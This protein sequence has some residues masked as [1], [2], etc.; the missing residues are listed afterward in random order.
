MKAVEALPL[1][2][3]RVYLDTDLLAPDGTCVSAHERDTQHAAK[4]SKESSLKRDF[5]Q[6]IDH[7]RRACPSLK[8]LVVE[9]GG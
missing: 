9:A 1:T 4:A 3:F 2:S 8:E 5:V 6:Y 7:V